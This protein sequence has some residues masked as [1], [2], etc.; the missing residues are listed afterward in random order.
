MSDVFDDRI[1]RQSLPNDPARIAAVIASDSKFAYFATSAFAV[2]LLR[3]GADGI[4]A[5]GEHPQH[6]RHVVPGI[7]RWVFGV[8]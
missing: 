4:E 5:C 3:R 6:R 7:L 1:D 8:W 2:R